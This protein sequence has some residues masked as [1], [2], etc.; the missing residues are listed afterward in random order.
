[1]I[2]DTFLSKIF[3]TFIDLS[4]LE[5]ALVHPS[6]THSQKVSD[7]ERL[8]FLGDRVL[9]LVVAQMIYEK[10]PLEKEGDLAKRLAALVS[11]DACLGIAE[12]IHLSEH[13]KTSLEN[14]PSHSAIFA[15]GVEALIGALYLDGGL[16]AA[17]LFIKTYWNSLLEKDI[18]PPQDSKT[19]LQELVQSQ[20][21]TISP[22]Y[23]VL[24]HSGPAHT[25]TFIVRVSVVGFGNAEGQGSSKR[26]AEQMAAKTLLD[27]ITKQ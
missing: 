22:I 24:S 23:E 21:S 26:Q 15:D 16:E 27:N 5:K 19:T 6:S 4:L 8:E 1:M 7:F 17:T 25:P 3:H 13:L 10:Y 14:R 2:P 20:N 12:E 9:G 11:R 18:T